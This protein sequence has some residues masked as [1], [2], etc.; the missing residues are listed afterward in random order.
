MLEN[1]SSIQ[2]KFAKKI[3]PFVACFPGITYLKKKEEKNVQ[4]CAR[5]CIHTLSLAHVSTLVA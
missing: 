5:K 3:N 4:C 1:I 2:E